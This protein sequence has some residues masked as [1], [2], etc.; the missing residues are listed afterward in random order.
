MSS[1]QSSPQPRR[2]IAHALLQ[3][4]T[5]KIPLLRP[6]LSMQTHSMTLRTTDLLRQPPKIQ[7]LSVASRNSLRGRPRLPVVRVISG[8]E[9]TTFRRVRAPFI[10]AFVCTHCLLVVFPLIFHSI[11][12]EIPQD[13]RALITRIF[14][15]W[16]VLCVTLLINMIACI[17]ILTSGGSDGGKDLAASI[18][19]VVSLSYN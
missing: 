3:T 1:A 13:S 14:Q 16:L 2:S 8:M 10:V 9:R 15:L 5:T 4:H 18:R 7:T 11:N 17:F 19:H 6:I 12:D